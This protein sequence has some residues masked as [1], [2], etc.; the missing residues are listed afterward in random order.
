MEKQELLQVFDENKNMIN[1]YVERKLK[2]TLKDGK[3]FMIVLL[4]IENNNKFLIQKVSKEKGSE[5]A[6]TGGHASFMDDSI[7]TVKKETKEEINI[8]FSDDELVLVDS[9]DYGNC[10]CDIYYSNKEINISDIKLQN[11]EVEEI[12]WLSKEEILDLI[13]QGKFRKGN[14]EPFD[15][16][17]K[18]K[19]SL[20]RK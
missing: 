3:H 10:F 13:E 18:Y 6:T 4:F 2:K 20:K 9:I 12:F 11:E 19:E 14:I 8:E 7:A 16:V 17:L 1:E 5:I 15:K